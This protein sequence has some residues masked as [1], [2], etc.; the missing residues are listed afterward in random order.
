V[1]REELDGLEIDVTVLHPLEPIADASEL[2][3]HRYGVVVR[4][5]AGHQAVLLP[6]LPGID[7]VATQLRIVRQ[8]GHI[9][10]NAPI[11]MQRFLAERFTE[12]RT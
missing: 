8:K 11:K 12:Q 1:T 9:A 10:P 3:P 2:D 5:D 4:D 6:D 7:D